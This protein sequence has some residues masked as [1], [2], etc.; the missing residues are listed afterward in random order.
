MDAHEVIRALGLRP[1]PEGGYYRETYRSAEKVSADALPGRYGT[2][3]TIS[4]AIY[5]LLTPDSPSMLHR[6]NSDELFHFYFGDPV[7]MLQLHPG[8][9]SQRLT[10]GHD[11]ATGEQLQVLVPA[12]VWQGAYVDDGGRFALMG[13]T[14]APG[15]EPGDFELAGREELM[16]RYPHEAE[17]IERLT[18]EP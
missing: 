3:R 5:Y 1:H 12:G 17:L 6:V 9:R 4:T 18:A 11:I 10:L 15:F 14:V 13:C 16:S 7:A 2:Q 8:G